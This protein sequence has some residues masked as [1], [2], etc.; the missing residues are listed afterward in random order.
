MKTRR[1]LLALKALLFPMTGCRCERA[2]ELEMKTKRYFLALYVV[3]LFLGIFPVRAE[4]LGSVYHP[5]ALTIVVYGAPRDLELQVEMEY[6]GERFPVTLERDDRLWETQ[7]RLYREGA[8]RMKAWFGSEKD[9]DGAVLLV[10][11]GGQER[12]IPIEREILTPGSREDYL[13]FYARRDALRGGLPFWRGPL[14]FLVRMLL[15]L[16]VKALIFFWM[17]YRLPRSWLS[18]LGVELVVQGVLNWIIAG[19]IN[20]DMGNAYPLLFLGL[21]LAFLVEMIGMM[22]LVNERTK[23][24]TAS[25][26]AGTSLLGSAMIFGMLSYLPI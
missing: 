6:D 16:G 8:Y 19:W 26:A 24:K 10:H 11:S 5:P 1:F 18:F 22:V 4:A 14:N 17:D 13:T 12:R 23:S 7:F 15:L 20:V 9:F 3:L 2:K 21:L 25:F